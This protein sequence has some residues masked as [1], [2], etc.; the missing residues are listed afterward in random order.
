MIY[1]FKLGSDSSCIF[2]DDKVLL[3][4]MLRDKGTDDQC[5]VS[6]ALMIPWPMPFSSDISKVNQLLSITAMLPL[7]LFVPH[8]AIITCTY[9][10]ALLFC[11]YCSLFQSFL[12]GIL[13]ADS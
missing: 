8:F 7:F 4:K 3:S 12:T 1:L 9:K 11:L 2:L 10:N 5:Q 13:T 6:N